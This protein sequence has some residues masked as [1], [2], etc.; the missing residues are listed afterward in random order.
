MPW[1]GIFNVSN[2]S[3]SAICENKILAKNS[4]FTVIGPAHVILVLIAMIELLS[5]TCITFV[6][7]LYCVLTDEFGTHSIIICVKSF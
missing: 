2:M 1:S 5:S 3:F 6:I 7:I 4:E